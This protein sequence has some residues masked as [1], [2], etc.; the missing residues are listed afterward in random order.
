MAHIDQIRVQKCRISKED[1]PMIERRLFYLQTRLDAT[2]RP[3]RPEGTA[4]GQ[5]HLG[6]RIHRL[7]TGHRRTTNAGGAR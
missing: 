7:I 5:A 3:H 6:G 4:E 2:P 1:L